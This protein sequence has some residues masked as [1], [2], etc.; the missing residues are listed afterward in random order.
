MEAYF[1]LPILRYAPFGG[2]DWW[3]PLKGSE[4]EAGKPWPE[5]QGN[6]RSH[7]TESTL[8]SRSIH[9]STRWPQDSG[10]A[11]A[12]AFCLTVQVE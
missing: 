5:H 1:C 11:S 4:W 12:N 2:L 8:T 7:Q 9:Q 3:N 10:G 6:P